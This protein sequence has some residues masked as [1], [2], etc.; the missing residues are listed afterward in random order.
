M[1]RV[2]SAAPKS[3]PAPTG[4]ITNVVL[5]EALAADDVDVDADDA[6]DD[7]ASGGG[8]W[9]TIFSKLSSA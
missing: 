7:P 2:A 9:R 6:D 5:A 3:V 4:R 1:P 8:A